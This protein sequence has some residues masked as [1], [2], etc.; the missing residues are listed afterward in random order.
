MTNLQTKN[1]ACVRHSKHVQFGPA[2]TGNK[3]PLTEQLHSSKCT[4]TT[5]YKN[6]FKKKKLKKIIKTHTTALQRPFCTYTG[7]HF[8][9]LQKHRDWSCVDSHCL[10]CFSANVLYKYTSLREYLLLL[11]LYVRYKHDRI[12]F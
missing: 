8:Q 5:F 11:C 6:T 9:I 3:S 12:T 2:N 7:K 10:K 4:H 1:K